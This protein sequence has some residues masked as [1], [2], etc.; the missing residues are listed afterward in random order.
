MTLMVWSHNSNP[1]PMV[2]SRKHA[3]GLW[4]MQ[5][6]QPGHTKQFS[7]IWPHIGPRNVGAPP[8]QNLGG[9]NHPPYGQG[10]F[11]G[12]QQRQGKQSRS[13]KEFH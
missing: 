2:E 8:P 7:G 5:C 10:N 6:G 9:P 3:S 11:K 4:C 12:A 1:P 13:R